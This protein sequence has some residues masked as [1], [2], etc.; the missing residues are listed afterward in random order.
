MYRGDELEG[1][2]RGVPATSNTAYRPTAAVAVAGLCCF[3]RAA[4]AA[5]GE[6]EAEAD[7]AVVGGRGRWPVEEV[8][9]IA[10]CNLEEVFA[11]QNNNPNDREWVHVRIAHDRAQG[12]LTSE[13]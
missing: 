11:L 10:G 4:L 9:M 7:E 2:G 12:L 13:F 3:Q 6:S 5:D 8:S 1:E